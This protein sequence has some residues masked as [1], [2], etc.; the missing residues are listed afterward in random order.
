[1]RR[2]SQLEG[3]LAGNGCS[4]RHKFLHQEIRRWH[5][6]GAGMFSRR[7]GSVL[8]AFSCVPLVASIMEMDLS[9]ADISVCVD[10]SV[11]FVDV[12]LMVLKVHGVH[13]PC[14]DVLPLKIRA[15][16]S[17]VQINHQV[18]AIKL[19]PWLNTKKEKYPKL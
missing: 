12:E 13:E 19:R 18:T 4:L 3:R 7:V 11:Q 5:E 1:M 17:W 16:E 9:V 8:Q 10:G 6:G 2:L 15:V 14:N